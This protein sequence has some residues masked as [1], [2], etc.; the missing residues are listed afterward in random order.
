M[1]GFVGAG[2]FASI[3]EA[4]KSMVH[5]TSVFEPDMERYREYTELFQNVYQQ[6]YPLSRIHI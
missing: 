4:V 1:V 5:H 2:E 3:E 6:M